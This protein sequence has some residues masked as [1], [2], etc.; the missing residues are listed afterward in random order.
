MMISLRKG[1][2]IFFNIVLHLTRYVPANRTAALPMNPAVETAEVFNQAN[3]EPSKIQKYLISICC[4]CLLLPGEE[5]NP[6]D[7]PS[8]SSSGGLDKDVSSPMMT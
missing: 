7:L 1:L 2:K 5:Y 4:C 3:D 6:M 8:R